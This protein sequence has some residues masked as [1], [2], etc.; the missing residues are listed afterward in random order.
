MSEHPPPKENLVDRERVA[1]V[2][3][4]VR[5]GVRLRQGELA[6]LGERREETRL[7][8][9]E[10]RRRE[11]VDEPLPVSPRPVL[12]RLLVFA[13]KGFFHLF[14]KWFARPV[15]E[16]QNA[17]NRIAGQLLEELTGSQERLLEALDGIDRRLR[18]LEERLADDPERAGDG[19]E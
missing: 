18:T 1:E 2:L 15:L 4:R 10:L 7:Q 13:R 14:A 17:Y 19:T 6:S 8:L 16:Q 9:A 12:G 3:E 11:F 5:A